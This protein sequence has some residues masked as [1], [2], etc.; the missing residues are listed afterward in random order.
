MC[1]VALGFL[2]L[3]G[4]VLQ[5]W[6][7]YYVLLDPTKTSAKEGINALVGIGGGLF[8]SVSLVVTFF[9]TGSAKTISD[10]YKFNSAAT[11]AVTS[12]AST[13]AETITQEYVDKRPR[14]KD[15]DDGSVD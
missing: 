7:C 13:V 4:T 10:I 11:S 6:L 9:I 2:Y 5:H 3:A 15:L 1:L 8:A 14:P 12:T